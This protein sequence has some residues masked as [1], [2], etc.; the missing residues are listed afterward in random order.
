ME[1]L[2]AVERVE[3]PPHMAMPLREARKSSWT[4]EKPVWRLCHNQHRL[5]RNITKFKLK[6]DSL[7]EFAK[8]AQR[9]DF[10]FAI[11]L[12]SAYTHILIHPKH[13]RFMGFRFRGQYYVMC[14]LPFGLLCAPWLFT[15]FNCVIC[16]FIRRTISS[17]PLLAYIDD[18]VASLRSRDFGTMLE[19]LG[20]IRGFGFLVNEDKCKLELL[21]RMEALGFVIDTTTM[22]FWLL[23]R[24]LTAWRRSPM[25]F[26]RIYRHRRRD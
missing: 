15:C 19:V 10:L 26:V 16:Q 14:G 7:R 9:Y 22:T 17:L 4:A 21:Q 2:G 6:P 20:I 11:D 12:T 1:R 3:T 8:S 18:F 25:R 13:R 24:R 23:E 5:N